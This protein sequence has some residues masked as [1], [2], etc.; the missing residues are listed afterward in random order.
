IA[1]HNEHRIAT[2]RLIMIAIGRLTHFNLKDQMFLTWGLACLNSILVY[3][4]GRRT[5]FEGTDTPW[6]WNYVAWFLANLMIFSLI[7]Y[8]N[9]LWAMQ[10]CFQFPTFCLLT[11]SLA[12]ISP[13]PRFL[14]IPAAIVMS[15]ISTYS[16]GNG[17]LL[18]IVLLPLVRYAGK[19]ASRIV[20]DVWTACWAVCAALA[21]GSYFHGYIKPAAHP[22]ILEGLYHPI[23]FL[24]YFLANLGSPLGPGTVVDTIS[25]S[26]AVGAVVFL[27]FAAAAL[28]FYKRRHDHPLLK[29][30]LP[31][32]T[33]G[34]YV[35]SSALINDLARVG[36]GV[37]HA[38]ESGYTSISILMYVALIYLLP[39]LCHDALETFSGQGWRRQCALAATQLPPLLAGIM[40]VLYVP[41]TAVALDRCRNIRVLRSNGRTALTFI[42]CFEDEAL[43]YRTAANPS[44]VPE[45]HHYADLFNSL[46]Y[47]NPPLVKTADIKPLEAAE[48]R[49]LTTPGYYGYVDIVIPEPPGNFGISGWA[50]LPDH[51][52]P[53]DGVL[54]T[55][56]I[57]DADP[58][59]F[60]IG[61]G[62]QPSPN[63]V[64]V[65]GNPNY[66]NAGF[67]KTFAA[68][69]IPKGD[70]KI[71]AWAYD[72]S[73]QKAYELTGVKTIH[74]GP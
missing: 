39:I 45:V 73:T 53:A 74:N 40:L 61:D 34:A 50:V 36:F 14:S 48:Q 9:W 60:G 28:Y 68:A 6:P 38:L 26:I 55:Y 64:V 52:A 2:D 1:L 13:L 12:L 59:V 51:N 5:W 7:Q 22:S 15:V 3:R 11:A 66:A 30:A 65:T 43:D 25:Q 31:C 54:L 32:L 37:N 63:V 72:L 58:V 69:S 29:R 24:L 16:L 62:G 35:V 19:P 21:I 8:D 27:V 17:M 70:L 49:S 23:Q 67:V 57:G 18:W 10:I 42:D 20:R 41:C 33:V 47:L 44:Q 46:G 56:Q 4:L 71:Q